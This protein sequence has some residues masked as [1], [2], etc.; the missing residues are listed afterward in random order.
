MERIRVFEAFAG[1]GS[2]SIALERLKENVTEFDYEVV[3]I[4]EI[5]EYALKAYYAN[6]DSGI[7]NYGDIRT[8]DWE[9]VPDF[10]LF[11]MSAPC[12]DFSVAGLQRGCEEGSGTRS[13][14]L[15]ECRK[16][17]VAKKPK[18][19]FFENVKAM[20]SKKFKPYFDKWMAELE[21]YGYRNFYK[22]IDA[23]YHL[24]PQHRERL[25]AISI[26][27]CDFE[28]HFP[29]PTKFF[30]PLKFFLEKRVDDSFYF[31]NDKIKEVIDCSDKLKNG[32]SHLFHCGD[33]GMSVHPLSHR[34]EWRGYD[35]VKDVSPTLRAT[36]YKCPVVVWEILRDNDIDYLE[37]SID[38]VRIRK[39]IPLEYFRLMGLGDA[40]A[41]NIIETGLSNSRMYRMAG[42]SIVVKVMCDIFIKLFID[43]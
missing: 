28:Y 11:T 34:F 23:Q 7:P 1:Y 22:V 42:E 8:I 10:D 25:Y 15:W 6:H 36:D 35:N 24:I 31:S 16:A 5:D 13:S 18:Y 2:Q 40:E 27:D 3:G 20:L 26:R 21:S 29:K 39:A 9:N 17:I 41:K 12:Q 32:F 43:R 4:S 14:L 30:L 33:F 37:P 38:T 19:I